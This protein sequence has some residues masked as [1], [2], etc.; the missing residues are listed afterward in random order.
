MEVEA[1]REKAPDLKE[2]IE[3][4]K[5][6]SA[7]YQNEWPETMPA[8]QSEMMAFFEACHLLQLEVMS[9]I[10]VA[11]DLA[12]RYFDQFCSGK[13]HNLRL[14]R[15]PEAAKKLFENAEQ[16]RRVTSEHWYSQLIV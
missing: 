6:P 11:L 3:I 16:T 12:P 14:L 8:M 10:A 9:A 5:E 13:D 1:L 4:G 7:T 15:Y 2:S